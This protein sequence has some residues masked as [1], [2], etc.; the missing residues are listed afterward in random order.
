MQDRFWKN[1]KVMITGHTGFKGSWLTLILSQMGAKVVGYSLNPISKPNF[2]DD[3]NLKRYL[4]KDIRSNIL[5]YKKLKK[6]IIDFKPDILFHLAAQSSVL[7]SYQSPRETLETNIIGT[8]NILHILKD[9]KSIKSSIIVTT[10]KVYLNLEKKKKFKELDSLGGYD[11]YSGS[12]AAC[13]IISHSYFQ[14]FFKKSNCNIAT[15]RSGNC[16]GGGDWTKD[17]IVKDCAELF[18][19]NKNLTIRSPKASRPWQHVLEPIFGYLALGEKL[20][21]DKKY[22]GGWNFAPSL[23]NNLK[24]KE[25][26][27]YGKKILNSKSKNKTLKQVYYESINLSL[28]SKKALKKLKWKNLYNAKESLKMSFDWYKF[29]YE[30]KSKSKSKII[31]FTFKQI[32]NYFKKINI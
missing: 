1:K 29:Y 30:N 24:V 21:K 3:C 5:N 28:S 2:F 26:A 25:V 14:S 4:K 18:I 22:I 10:D 12:K 13:E 16:I 6:S 27:Y 20:F 15:V 9:S 17:R 23:K 7:E 8:S 31:N 19:L 32:N 11:I